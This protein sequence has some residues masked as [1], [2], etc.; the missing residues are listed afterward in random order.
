MPFTLKWAK[1]CKQ[2]GQTMPVGTQAI[3]AGATKEGG[4]KHAL[5]E[6]CRPLESASP[7][8]TP[9]ISTA[10]SPAGDWSVTLERVLPTETKDGS[11]LIRIA[12]LRISEERAW[13]VARTLRTKVEAVFP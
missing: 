12:C 13:D 7:A 4:L 6:Q 8:P 3:Y 10:V 11:T 9:A 5:V 2:C 1:P